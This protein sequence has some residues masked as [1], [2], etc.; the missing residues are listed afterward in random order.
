MGSAVVIDVIASFI[1]DLSDEARFVIQVAASFVAALFLLIANPVWRWF[2]MH[3]PFKVTYLIPREKYRE[4]SFPG[5]ESEEKT[6]S[7]LTVGIGYYRVMHLI[8]PKRE[9]DISS[10]KLRFSGP[11]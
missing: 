5:A 2:K 6:A 4:I 9:I 3:D 11:N 1:Q 7:E 10:V 8:I